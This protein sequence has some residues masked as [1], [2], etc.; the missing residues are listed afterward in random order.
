MVRLEAKEIKETTKEI[1]GGQSE[2]PLELSQKN[3][4]FTRFGGRDSFVPGSAADDLGGDSACT[5]E[6]IQIGLADVRALPAAR[7]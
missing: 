2:S 4:P 3:N 5:D 7:D 1:T 6:P